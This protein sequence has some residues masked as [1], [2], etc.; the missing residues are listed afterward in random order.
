MLVGIFTGGPS[1][2]EKGFRPQT[3]M[4]GSKPPV[5]KSFAASRCS[6]RRYAPLPNRDPLG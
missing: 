4:L 5:S 6:G 1:Q 3:A 2:K